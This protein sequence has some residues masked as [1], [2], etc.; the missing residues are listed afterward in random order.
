MLIGINP[1]HLREY[2][3][4]P[5]LKEFDLWS[6]SAENLLMGTAAQESKLGHYLKQ[7]NGP[8]LGIYQME[9]A[10]Y[11]DILAN[12]L[13]R[14]QINRPILQNYKFS[15]NSDPLIYDLQLAT[16]MCRLQYWR[17]K[18]P[19]PDANDIEG[20]ANYWKKYYNTAKGKGTIYGF[21]ENYKAT[22]TEN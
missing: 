22:I 4:K 17:W 10:T 16:L 11:T 8:A 3:I 15:D 19:L 12:V 1:Y 21:M 18:E 13:I 6:K 7:I 14:A 9:P 2:V 5:T 20:L